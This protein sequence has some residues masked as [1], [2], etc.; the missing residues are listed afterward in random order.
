M[1]FSNGNS[2]FLSRAKDIAELPYPEGHR[3][4]GLERAPQP[5]V[6]RS[7]IGAWHLIAHA[8]IDDARAAV[9]FN[10]AS[11]VT[12]D[13]PPATAPTDAATAEP[14]PQS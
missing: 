4:P 9:A 14:P 11:P 5:L 8:M 10:A 6:G 13:A 7:L 2:R 12:T 1:S 3:S